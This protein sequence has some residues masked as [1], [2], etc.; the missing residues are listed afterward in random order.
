MARRKF[1]G[2]TATVILTGNVGPVTPGGEFD[3]PDELVARFDARRDVTIPGRKRKA[4]TGQPGDGQPP[5]EPGTGQDGNDP[6]VTSPGT[7]QEVS[8]IPDNQ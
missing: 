2:E 4:R 8:V 7:T 3:V 6:A 5:G 1:T